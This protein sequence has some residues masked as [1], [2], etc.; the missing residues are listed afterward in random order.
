MQEVKDRN[1]QKCRIK[2]QTDSAGYSVPGMF[3]PLFALS[4]KFET[5]LEEMLGNMVVVNSI[6]LIVYRPFRLLLK[7]L[8]NVHVIDLMYVLYKGIYEQVVLL[9]FPV[10]ICSRAHCITRTLYA[11]PVPSSA[12]SRICSVKALDSA[13]VREEIQALKCH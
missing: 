11:R 9:E 7:N 5:G 10:M 13:A 4:N 8:V 2:R 3:L 1:D 6:F 12:F